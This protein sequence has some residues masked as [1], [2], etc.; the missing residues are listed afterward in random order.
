M[1]GGLS[2]LNSITP[3]LEYLLGIILRELAPVIARKVLSLI[4]TIDIVDITTQ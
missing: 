1:H 4:Q 2:V 3:R